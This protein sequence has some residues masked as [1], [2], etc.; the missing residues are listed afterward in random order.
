M[1]TVGIDLGT[2]MSVVSFMDSKVP[3]V[4]KIDDATT[5]PS[6]VSYMDGKPLVGQK[7]IDQASQFNTVFSVKRFM[8]TKIQFSERNAA[9]ISGDIL[10]YLK[11]ATEQTLGRMVDAAIITV[12]A[13]FSDLQRTATKQAASI[14]G[15]KV[16]RLINEPTAAAIAFGLDKQQADGIYAVY[17]LGGGTFDFSVLRLSNNVFQVLATGGDNYLGGDNI[18]NAILNYNFQLCGLHPNETSSGEMIRARLVAKMLKEELKGSEEICRNCIFENQKYEFRLSRK[19]L[20]NLTKDL[21]KRTF[22]ISDQVISDSNVVLENISGI[23]LVGGMTKLQL[24][25][26]SVA[27]HFCIKIFDKIN[28][29]EVVAQG[30]AIYANSVAN[31]SNALLIDVVPLTLGVETFGGGVD[32]IVYRNTPIPIIAEREYTTYQNNQVGIKF[33]IVQGESSIADDCRSLANFELT[34]IPPMPAGI[35]RII[36]EFSVDVNGL[37]SVK[38]Y[39]KKSGISQSILIEPS[40]GLSNEEMASIL[41]KV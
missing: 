39:E 28:P 16:L 19:T 35:P 24:I 27:S 17:D 11:N 41:K 20:K 2:T 25:K 21:L 9:E 12:P 29:E 36:V 26:D 6:V 4:L 23:V 7:A 10:A 32:K 18:D 8:G 34:N 33:H 38:A 1:F 15:I 40:S 30:A 13:H 5:I 31:E 3:K 14:A 22:E 37:L